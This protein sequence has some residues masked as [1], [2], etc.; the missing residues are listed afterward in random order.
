MILT[1]IKV[2]FLIVILFVSFKFNMVLCI[3]L[4]EYYPEEDWFK[5]ARESPRVVMSIRVDFEPMG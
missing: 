4:E 3:E 1:L 5:D 2:S